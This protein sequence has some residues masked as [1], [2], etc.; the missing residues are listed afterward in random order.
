L[1]AITTPG[2]FGNPALADA[3]VF[4]RPAL[5]LP[6]AMAVLSAVAVIALALQPSAPRAV[7][8]VAVHALDVMVF[9]SLSGHKLH[10]PKGV[11]VPDFIAYLPAP[12]PARRGAGSGS[13]M[14]GTSRRATTSRSTPIING[15]DPLGVR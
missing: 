4:L 5:A 14:P 15:Y 12:I 7:F 10:C 1:V 11:G 13:R 9:A 6:A 8:L 3:F 2:G